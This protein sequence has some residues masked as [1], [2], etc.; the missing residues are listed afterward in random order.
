MEPVEES[1]PDPQEQIAV[2]PE[3]VKPEAVKPEAAEEAKKPAKFGFGARIKGGRRQQRSPLNAKKQQR[4]RYRRR[5]SFGQRKP[6]QVG[7]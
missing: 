5:G 1:K 2:K 3:A 7:K 4:G 6:K